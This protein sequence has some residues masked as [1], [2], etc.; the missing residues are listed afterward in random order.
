M[1]SEKMYRVLCLE[2][3]IGKPES[4]KP[5]GGQTSHSE[6]GVLR[7]FLLTDGLLSLKQASSQV[8]YEAF[9][10]HELLRMRRLHNVLQLAS[11]TAVATITA[12]GADARK[13][14]H[15]WLARC[16]YALPL[17][18]PSLWLPLLQIR[19]HR[20]GRSPPAVA[21]PVLPSRPSLCVGRQRAK[22]RA[23][24]ATK[25]KL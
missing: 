7:R 25:H 21:T 24:C 22:G 11:L 13:R 4:A 1:T 15:M 23:L 12:A 8:N 17:P 10:T 5:K 19:W 3:E 2:E 18:L 6:L 20:I 14:L 16:G 9:R